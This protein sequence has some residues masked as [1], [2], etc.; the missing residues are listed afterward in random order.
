M[1]G[2]KNSNQ[3]IEEHAGAIEQFVYHTIRKCVEKSPFLSNFESKLLE[4]TSC[5]IEHFV[6]SIEI[7]RDDLIE[8]E[9]KEGSYELVD[10]HFLFRSF[11][12]KKN[13]LP[14]IIVKDLDTP[15]ISLSLK[16][17]SIAA[18]CRQN[19]I[20]AHIEGEES[21]LLRKA[22][23]E[24]Q[25]GL[26]LYLVER[27]SLEEVSLHLLKNEDVVQYFQCKEEWNTRAR[28]ISSREDEEDALHEVLFLVEKLT[29][30]LGAKRAASLILSEEMAYFQGK[31]KAAMIQGAR[32]FGLGLGWKNLH[33]LTFR[34]SRRNYT[35]TLRFIE[36]VGFQ[37]E[38]FSFYGNQT[39]VGQKSF[40]H[41]HLGLHATVEVD[42]TDKEAHRH[43]KL[44]TLKEWAHL[45]E[46]GLWCRLNGES[47]LE[48]GC[49]HC[50]ICANP[51]KLTHD[52]N[53][54]HI[55]VRQQNTGALYEEM[56]KVPSNMIE[57]LLLERE[58]HVERI[59]EL[60]KRGYIRNSF[61]AAGGF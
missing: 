16:V 12:H 24:R 52:L 53:E 26:F 41:P 33:S 4:E 51:E 56:Y 22:L 8:S 20:K 49:S 36:M 60:E 10:A 21:G 32:Q 17:D 19:C 25:S 5:N 6:D 39:G 37:K 28:R 55:E 59:K 44:H 3:A 2:E 1:F 45:G 61:V 35:Q 48:A 38:G 13:L 15:Y 14:Q 47:L 34:T 27:K 23:I 31:N 9:L 43:E 29:Q 58:V 42:M 30:K 57:K 18:F 50:M 40:Y 54:F 7:G 11:A 46:I